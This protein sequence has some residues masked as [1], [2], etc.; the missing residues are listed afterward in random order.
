MRSQDDDLCS[1]T[2]SPE[3]RRAGR[4]HRDILVVALAILAG[5]FLLDVRDGGQVGVRGFP[6]WTLPGTCASRELFGLN[7]PGCGLTRSL[8][9]LAHGEWEGAQRHHRL[10]WLVALAVA[11]QIPFRLWAIRDPMRAAPWTRWH[12]YFM[13]GVAGVLVFNWLLHQ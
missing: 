6:G 3:R 8:V 2:P 9:S 13:M 10:G 4:Q 1:V 5:A 11:I 12:G 7:C